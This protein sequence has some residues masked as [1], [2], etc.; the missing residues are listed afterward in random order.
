MVHHRLNEW[1][2]N[3]NPYVNF[4]VHLPVR[5][6]AA[7]E[8]SRQLLRA[9]MA[10]VKPVMKAH[11]LQVNSIEE[12]QYNCAHYGVLMANTSSEQTNQTIWHVPSVVHLEVKVTGKGSPNNMAFV[13]SCLKKEVASLPAFAYW[14]STFIYA[15]IG[16]FGLS[17]VNV[18]R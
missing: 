2:A 10:Q 13:L 15:V 12:Y 6:A 17:T 5:D 9:L 16:M 18:N 11:Q 14:S 8:D 7:Q 4:I 1:E 3:P